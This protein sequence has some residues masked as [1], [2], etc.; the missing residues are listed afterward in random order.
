M[1]LIFGLVG[2]GEVTIAEYYMDDLPSDVPGAIPDKGFPEISKVARYILQ[3]KVSTEVSATKRSFGHKR[4]QFHYR[5]TKEGL[6][7]M[8]V[9]QKTTEEEKGRVKIPYNCIEDILSEFLGT[10]HVD[11]HVYREHELN[12][13]FA[14]IIRSK[15]EHWNRPDA[16]ISKRTKVKVEEVKNQYV[17]MIDDVVKRGD[18]AAQLEERASL[19]Q[20][21]GADLRTNTKTMSRKLWW[22]Q[23]KFQIIAFIACVI[24]TI[25][26]VVILVWAL[27]AAANSGF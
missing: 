11:G 18:Q 25:I 6:C 26:I 13:Q 14:P 22:K 24:C 7:F 10:Y 16:D 20:D 19:L 21:E 23:K 1:A 4:H 2:Q 3:E 8:V 15:L 9:T 12:D 5:V 27:G 17:D